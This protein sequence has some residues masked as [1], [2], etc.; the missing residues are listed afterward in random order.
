[1]SKFNR[2]GW[3]KIACDSISPSHPQPK[4]FH[5]NAGEIRLDIENGSSIHHVYAAYVKC[6]VLTSKQFHNSKA[7]RI[8]PVWRASG[9]DT[10][11]PSVG[12]RRAEKLKSIGAVEFPDH[13]QVRETLD[14]GESS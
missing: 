4:L 12:W 3:I 14:V 13:E 9:E 6:S 5:W 1:M 10:M 2:A 8:W 7:K 11:W